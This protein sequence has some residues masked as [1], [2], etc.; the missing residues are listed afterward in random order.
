M[1]INYVSI[2]GRGTRVDDICSFDFGSLPIALKILCSFLHMFSANFICIYNIIH[3]L[4]SDAFSFNHAWHF[5]EILFV[6][7]FAHILFTEA[8]I[9][10]GSKFTMVTSTL[11]STIFWIV[12][13]DMAIKSLIDSVHR[14]INCV[15]AS[16]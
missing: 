13:L 5:T 4:M 3:L 10:I 9:S 6:Q 11:S 15:S 8:N 12:K 1:V 14:E 7:I 2:E 16:N